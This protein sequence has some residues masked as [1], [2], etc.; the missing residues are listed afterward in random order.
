MTSVSQS[1]NAGTPWILQ[2]AGQSSPWARELAELNADSRINTQL[3]KID[4]DA[5]SMLGPV[6][7][8]LTVIGAGRLDLLGKHGTAST[9]G[10]A[11]ASVPGILLA[12]YG[13][14]CDLAA[15]LP[16]P[17]VEIIGHSQGILAA[18][19]LNSDAPASIFA[20][21][22]LIGAAATKVTREVGAE[23][24][25]ESTSMLAVRGVPA[26]MLRQ[27]L[28]DTSL[29]IVNSRTSTVLSGK[30]CDLEN[31]IEKIEKLAKA[32]QSERSA[33][34]TG[35]APL[36]PVTEFL[37][38]DAP[39][40]S[41]LLEPAVALVDGWIAAAGL[42]IA[43]AHD[44]AR[45]VLTD[46]LEWNAESADA[47]A[48]LGDAHG[49][50]GFVIDLGPGS[51][52]R[53]TLE[54][55][56][57][58]GVT[59]INAGSASARDEFI[60]GQP[61]SVS[62]EDWSKWAPS[63]AT[64]D[65]KKVVETAFT[66]L[67][68]RSPIILGGMTPTTVDPEIVAAAANAG[69]WVEL[70]G[71]GQVTEDVLEGNLY[72]LKKQLAPGRTAQFNAMF[73]DRYLWDLHF[74]NRRLVSRERG[75]GAPLDG[76]TISAGIP[77]LE[78]AVELIKRL[79]GEG[80]PYVAFKPGTVDQIRQVLAIARASAGL[81]LIMQVEDGHAGGHHSWE[82][83]DQLLLA[84]YREVRETGIVLAVGGGLGVPERAA[85]YLTG[86]W[87]YK[88]SM[89]AMP[90]DAIFIGT[91]A[92]TAKEAKT[93]RDVKELLV[94]TSGVAAEDQGG[95][96]ASGDVRGG[97]TSGLSQLRAD[98]YQVE[99]SAAACGRLLVTVDKDAEAVE[100]RREEILE[101]INKTAK[102]YFGDLEQM[103]YAQF[104]RRYVELTHPWTD[105]GLVQRFHELLQRCE[106][107]LCPADHG[108]WETVFPQI[109][110]VEDPAA[111][112]SSFE[113]AYPQASS[114]LVSA[115][116]AAWFISL[117]RKYPKPVP[118][119]PIIGADILQWWG[120][121]SLW[122]SQDPRYTADQV[123][124]IPGPVS[125]AG[126]T[127]VD[128]PVAQILARFEDAT[129]ER[130]SGE[131]PEV[132]SLL[133]HDRE[134]FVRTVPYILWHGQLAAN[135]AAVVDECQLIETE[136]GLELYLPLDTFWEGTSANQHAVRELRIPILLPD[137]VHNG[138]LPIVDDERLPQAMRAL[139]AVTAGVGSTTI[140]GTPIEELPVFEFND[141]T[142]LNEASFEFAVSAEI[143][144]LHAGVTAPDSLT[145]V[146]VPSALL[147]SCWPTIYAAIGAGV[148]H[149]YPVIEGLLSAVHLDH[150]ELLH[151]PL[152]EI[153]A[154]GTLTAHS[155]CE[156]IAESSAGRVVTIKTRVTDPSGRTVINFMERFAMRG[157]VTTTEL[158]VDP[159]PRG[160]AAGEVVDTARS[161][162]RRVKVT[163]P[164][165]MT[166]FAIVSGDFNPIHTS[167]RAAKVSGMDDALVH[168]MWLC[169]AA[170][171]TV[172][173]TADASGL[174]IKGWTYRM[175]GMVNLQDEVE[176]SAERV[177]RIRD[178]GLA[179][180]VTCRIDGEIVAQATAQVEA[181]STAYVYPGQGIQT[182]GMALDERA[183]SPAARSVWERADVHT[184][185]ALGFSILAVVQDNPKELTARG[186]TYRHPE[187]VLNL[188][189]FTQVALATVAIAQTERLREAGA[190]VDGAMFAGHSLGEYT[191][192]SAYA[193]VF[194]LENVL[195]IV[196]QR[197][198]TMHH[199]VPR[200]AQG[201]SNYRLGALRPNQLGVGA[202][203]VV[204]F[205]ASVA[206]ASGEF[207]EVVNLNLAGQ[208]Y[209]IAGTI[210][211]L[212]ALE[213]E[214][215][216][217]AEEFGGRR[218]F[219]LIPG[220]DVPF[221]SSVLRPGVPDFR[222]LL[223]GLLP[224]SIDI[225]SLQ[226]RYVPN[227]VARPFELTA[228][229]A[230]SILEV[231]PSESIAE[232]RANFD[233]RMEDPNEVA[234]TLLVELLAWQFASP[235]R[236]IETQEILIRDGVEE[237]VEVGLAS[238]PTLAN[239]ITKTLALPEH[240]GDD[241]IVLNVQRD[242]K[243]VLRED[244]A[245]VALDS[246][247]DSISGSA[248]DVAAPP[249]SETRVAEAPVAHVPAASA[250]VASGSGAP[251]ADIPFS[252]GNALR[253]L[254]AQET[255]VRLDQI[256]DVD[257]VE[258]LTNGVS[259]KRNQILM[260]MTAEFELA[261][262]DGAA[263]ASLSTLV[264]QVDQQ[265][266][267][268]HAFGPVLAEV[269][270]ERLRA[271]TGAAGAK[272][273]RVA[274]R[275]A[276]VWQLGSGWAAHVQAVIVL[277]TREGKS[278][279]GG[280][281]A[282]LAGQPSSTAELDA[283]VDEAI[284]E[285]GAQMGV[286][287][288]RPSA[289]A[290]GSGAVVDSAALDAF[291]EHMTAVLADTA[292]DLLARLG[293]DAPVGEPDSSDDA[294][295]RAAIAA[296]LGSG[297]ESFV[298]PAFD[299]NRAVH[300]NDRW[301]TAREDVARISFGEEIN[302][303]FYGTGEEVAR[304]AEWQAAR[305][306]ALAERLSQIAA[307]ARDTSAG[308]FTGKVA[309]VTGV[310][311][312]SIAGAAAARLLA[313]GATVVMTASRISTA[314]LS[315]AKELYRSNARG[316]AELWLVP[317]NL[318]SF[319]DVDSVIEWVGS[320]QRKTVGATSKLVK[321]A[322]TPD[323][324][325]PFAAPSVRG[326]MAEAGPEAENQARVLLWS[327]ER[328]V[329]GLS[330]IGEETNTE[331]RLH[332]ILPGSPNRGTF[333]GDGAYGEVKAAFD[334][335]CNKWN[336]EPWGA[337]TSLVQAKIGWVRGTGLMGHN[338]PLV[339]AVHAAGVR[340]WSTSEMGEQ[341][342]ALCSDQ[343]R[344]QASLAPLDVDLTG[345]LSNVDL[346]AL[347]ASSSVAPEADA[348]VPASIKALPNAKTPHQVGAETA[349]WAGVTARPEDMVVI[350]GLGEIGPW[351]SSRTRL[352]A[353][354]GIDSDGDVDMTAAGVLEMAWMMGLLTWHDT[355]QP[356]W[357]NTDDVLVDEADIWE[358]YRNEVVAR[359]GI[360][361]FVDDGALADLGTVDVAPV[362]LASDIT[363]GVADEAAA[364]AH[365]AAD[366]NFTTSAFVDGEWQVTRRA[367][368][369]TYVPRR[370]TLSR[371]VGGQFPTGF[372]PAHW[373]IPAAMTESMDRMAI[374][375]L[376]TTVDAFIGAGFSPA[377]LLAAVHPSEVA[378]TQ[379]TGFGG[380]TSMHR[381]YVDRF[382]G[383]EYPQD[384]L[385]ETLPNVVAAHTMQSYVG[386]YGS[387][388]H[389]VGACATAAVSVEEGA[390]KIAAGKATFVVAGAIDDLQIES[391][392][393]FG[394][395]NAT[396]NSQEMRD[397]GI[398]ERFFSRAGDA[399]RGGFVE[400]Q[401]GGTVLLARGDFAR[402][403]GLPVLGVVGYVHSYADGIHTSIPAPGQGALASVRGGENSQM[404]R[405]LAKLG[406][407]AD[408]IAVV[409]KHDTSTNANDPNEAELHVRIARELGR[410]A[411]NPL[412]V[413]SQKTLTGHA[414][415]GAALFQ[416]SGL[417]QLFSEG[418][419]PGNK[420]LDC[421]DE[422]FA[423]DD[424]L[425][426]LRDPLHVGTA[427][428]ALL[429]SLGFGHVAG[430][431]ALVHPGAFEKAI[432]LSDGPD[433]A[434]LWR[435]QADSRLAES[436][437]HMAAGMIG[438]EPLYE[439]VGGHRFTGD[440]HEQEARMLVDP[441]ARLGAEGTF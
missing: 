11:F 12:Q 212:K 114:T 338:D 383:K 6:L 39:F 172:A 317:A 188:T 167:Q 133:A 240:S 107:R 213:K 46:S 438:R 92:M 134:E 303:N 311:P 428:A 316:E 266:H 402:D 416:I 42:D 143:P 403:L 160:G 118:F 178:G 169:A 41:H 48:R 271:V 199:L 19:M 315:F 200:D 393:G 66:R 123:R 246:D 363:F 361:S 223:E 23:R 367:G 69:H 194:S 376:L 299:A 105:W 155:W 415:G 366:P 58:T 51:L 362:R 396:A 391:L 425:V 189:Q 119:V 97:I 163:A 220:I 305:N 380:M 267:G 63:L 226:G 281:L 190:L 381:L 371:T 184:R 161:L 294:D 349:D 225:V 401:G 37:D 378:S 365:I 287:V 142:G 10:S 126:I 108:L 265:A 239:M 409:S 120:S 136:A 148:A 211:G 382:V 399:R 112:I 312:S 151:V 218:P 320:Q 290:A 440:A 219:I 368:A 324:L 386:G 87:S 192:L 292:R 196:F 254:L 406:V 183:S 309:V 182:A 434:Q 355:P 67:T 258:T 300:L 98:I 343:T 427:K 251:A 152:D 229:F 54:N 191:A 154:A 397:K 52:Q 247:S 400:S 217:R 330:A 370:T 124:I 127:A 436:A 337:R 245:A 231:V 186:V 132:F 141:Q 206:E 348:V 394:D 83:L 405:S 201:Q 276:N 269:V 358:K 413:V 65:G 176:I 364:Q 372:D 102:P 33:K 334:A 49:T 414:K 106:A 121:D 342:A 31:I 216:R 270:G 28:G 221:H 233:Q 59:Y 335:I 145:S 398:S 53:L 357:Y 7:P 430:I 14:Y 84:T 262:L 208:Q 411:G 90:V 263:E 340:T 423:E 282:T 44:L 301:A 243:R 131:A 68:G 227:L 224:A 278:T 336:V 250:P 129:V 77:D 26:A 322:L 73:L 156:S 418:T 86:E 308:E 331:H 256:V 115:A 286:S 392:I 260:D 255:K 2:F 257:T 284:M 404:A 171:H 272:P 8:A 104:V 177:G 70:G 360:R 232:L 283:L 253:V 35:G 351:G 339:A 388:I 165:N 279:R 3:A 252:A 433:A 25:G 138:G 408:D 173:D 390:D 215:G 43:N 259:S 174:R 29:A 285:V 261:T 435:S 293:Q 72:E 437:R 244:V 377:E 17:P 325:L 237:I 369:V 125:V 353:E 321:P 230:D 57:G 347:K 242:S 149:G 302:A 109:E 203:D 412:Y 13:A 62:T 429:T 318:A 60:S 359:S 407:V 164:A 144:A 274:D 375:N 140:G 22:R 275:V 234:R 170:Q 209:A 389:P 81:P 193:K 222:N 101:A 297:W 197:G 5:E 326:T 207:L 329:A 346:R 354:L 431:L 268:Y 333:G 332:T 202:G 198:S 439:E 130:I 327:V 426:W 27:I 374:W 175:F 249:V 420:A 214:A 298:A 61:R 89:P 137:S 15:A 38:V 204:G 100:A 4:S 323:F 180:E 99:N 147:G 135:P 55:L 128:E 385:Q 78:E 288:S 110:S 210:A 307:Q 236:W 50:H 36:T 45:A 113:A 111:A 350:V 280:E 24:L 47:V 82:D 88:Y 18:A 158:P 295:L 424:F 195:E 96:V 1:L 314:R 74:G 139:L 417:V 277:G 373:G 306:P 310:T 432:E 179:L 122:Q 387:M 289:G 228:D 20:L 345:G 150:S 328:L 30:P 9:Q 162:L 187:G 291:S 159:A 313:G 71:G 16:T 79:R 185:E 421:Q 85:T 352:E 395:M 384:I 273:A 410:S 241:V 419:V 75:A 32:S 356:G 319:R 94:A 95:W 205:V 341:L 116:D 422:E 168:G 153:L 21:A 91:A 181:P 304:Q 264:A 379:G 64:I 248:D 157:R 76:V 166:A 238:S 146:A 34:L 441:A 80:F 235:V 117:C 56:A 40:H 103:T 93:N 344:A 296:E